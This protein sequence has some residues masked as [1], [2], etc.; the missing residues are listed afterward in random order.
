MFAEVYRVFVVVYRYYEF[1]TEK[2]LIRRVVRF[3][4]FQRFVGND[5]ANAVSVDERVFADF[6]VRAV[7]INA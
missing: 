3:V 7:K 2:V 4:F 1:G 5:Q 6:R